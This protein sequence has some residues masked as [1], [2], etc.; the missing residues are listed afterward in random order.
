MEEKYIPRFFPKI[1]ESFFLFGP[2]GTGKSTWIQK[3]LKNYLMIDLLDADKYRSLQAKP[4]RLKQEVEAHTNINLIVIDEVQKLPELLSI[5][6]SLMEKNKSLQFILT[7]SSARKI[8]RSGVDLLGGRAL[9]SGMHPF[10][11]GELGPLFHLEESLKY[12]LIPMHFFKEASMKERALNS[13]IDLYIKEEVQMESMVRNIGNFHRFLEAVSFSHSSI[14]NISNISREC[15]V[16]RKT[17]EGYINILY[18]LLLAYSIPVF[19]KRAKRILVQHPKF[20]FFDTGVYRTLRPKGPLDNPHEI[21][22]AALEGLVA[23][24]LKAWIDYTP[25][26]CSLFY[27]RTKSGSEVDFVIYSQKY[28]KAIEVKN[29]DK[30]RNEDLR[31]LKTFYKDYPESTP[32]FLYRGKE[33]LLIDNILCIPCQEFFLSLIPGT[34]IL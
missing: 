18:D 30:I 34:D 31:S 15:Q 27:W 10:M 29:S 12:G 1:K 17:V 7:G 4:E 33:R 26:P 11:A 14:L 23:Q 25:H 13:Y 21:D 5:V 16:Q 6:H 22:G 19:S 8:K 24:H 2:R 20:Y 3:N 28:F 9:K 32:I